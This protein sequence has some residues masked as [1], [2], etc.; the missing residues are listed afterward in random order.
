MGN[1][2]QGLNICPSLHNVNLLT[3]AEV[4]LLLELILSRF[5]STIH[6]IFRRMPENTDSKTFH[7]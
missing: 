3:Q 7:Y 5:Y 4:K 6:P 1:R 2:R